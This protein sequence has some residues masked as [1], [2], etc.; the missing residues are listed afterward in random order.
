MTNSVA[1]FVRHASTGRVAFTRVSAAIY[2][3][4]K[5]PDL[6]QVLEKLA[7]SG[8][9]QVTLESFNPQ[10][11]EYKALKAE[12]ALTRNLHGAEQDIAVE[13]SGAVTREKELIAARIDTI[14]ASLER[15]RWLPHELGTAY[16]M[17]NV[18]DYTLKVINQQQAVWSTRIVVGRPGQYATPL[19]AETVKN[20]T[21]NPTWNVP[22]SIIR[23]EYLPALERDPNSLAQIGLKVERDR[24]G[25]IHI[26][27]P[28]WPLVRGSR[29]SSG[30]LLCLNFIE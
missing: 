11:P 23:N 8:D 2:F 6:E 24:D 10:R 1:V 20:I 29:G 26:Y 3:D 17:V 15:W 28:P 25:S 30:P 16:V 19:L 27:Q 21:I 13:R 14:V 12:L 18:P 9:L 4:L 22:P 7:V 5:P